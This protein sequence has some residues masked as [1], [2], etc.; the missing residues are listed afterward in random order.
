MDILE[1]VPILSFLASQELMFY[2]EI[3]HIASY[4]IFHTP[5]WAKLMIVLPATDFL[6]E[7]FHLKFSTNTSFLLIQLF[8][9]Y[10]AQREVL[11]IS[12]GFVSNLFF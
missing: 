8:G 11:L 5:V 6:D 12:G 1:S 9:S 4:R 3:L 7:F 2:L 10:L